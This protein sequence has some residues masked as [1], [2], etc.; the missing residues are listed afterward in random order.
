M[1]RKST[2]LTLTA[3]GKIAL[4]ALLA[5]VVLASFGISSYFI[6]KSSQNKISAEKTYAYSMNTMLEQAKTEEQ[7]ARGELNNNLK[8]ARTLLDNSS[9]KVFDG[10]RS[11]LQIYVNNISEVPDSKQITS[12]NIN[13]Y[14]A[15]TKRVKEFNSSLLEKYDALNESYTAWSTTREK[16]DQESN[17]LQQQIDEGTITVSELEKLLANKQQEGEEAARERDELLRLLEQKK[18][19]NNTQPVKPTTPVEKPSTPTEKPTTPPTSPTPTTPTPTSTPTEKPTP[20]ETP[21][22]KPTTPPTTPPSPTEPT[23]TSEEAP[24]GSVSGN[25]VDDNDE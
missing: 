17:D 1:K 2:K 16:L 14:V 10:S 5:F 20:T 11:N 9:G 21:T 6:H 24:E 8:N 7:A 22:E 4:I 19:K 3:R 13:D 23:E 15:S 25:V 18:K 12:N